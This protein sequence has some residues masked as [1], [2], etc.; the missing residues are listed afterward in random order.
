[1]LSSIRTQQILVC[2]KDEKIMKCVI[3]KEKLKL[4]KLPLKTV[5]I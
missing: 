3:Y 1:M 5:Q 2:K 4:Y